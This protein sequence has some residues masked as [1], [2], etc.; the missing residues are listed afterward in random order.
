MESYPRSRSR[1]DMTDVDH[2]MNPILDNPIQ[3]TCSG[4]R[5]IDSPSRAY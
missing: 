5:A 2:T 4:Y 3:L 1:M